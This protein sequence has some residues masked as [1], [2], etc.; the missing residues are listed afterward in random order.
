MESPSPRTDPPPISPSRL[1][2]P[3]CTLRSGPDTTSL[4]RDC[5]QQS[6]E[7]GIRYLKRRMID[8]RA[9][10]LSL[11]QL[12]ALAVIDYVSRRWRLEELQG[13][14]PL[15][16]SVPAVLDR[17]NPEVGFW[18][19]GVL[20]SPSVSSTL[21]QLGTLESRFL[22]C[23]LI[24][25]TT[26][27]AGEVADGL[28][29]PYGATH[30]LWWLSWADELDCQLPQGV[31]RTK[32]VQQIV[33]DFRVARTRPDNAPVNDLSIEQATILAAEGEGSRVPDDWTAKLV[34]AQ[35]RNG[36]WAHN[37]PGSTPGQD[38]HSTMLAVWY[39]LTV[40]EPDVTDPGFFAARGQRLSV[41]S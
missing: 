34:A 12:N 39:L 30:L 27:V 10:A 32:V 21:G 24:P 7:A 15:A 38:W 35:L 13:A 26:T 5:A 40:S 2:A 3:V 4:A 19:A 31:D 33:A 16:S 22:Y 17:H 18:R 41:G 8:R 11:E 37:L 23:D 9:S 20:P 1:P 6:A 29:T 14:R 28:Q 36:A 25:L